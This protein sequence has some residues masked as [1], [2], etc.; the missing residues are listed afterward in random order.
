MSDSYKPR[1]GSRPLARWWWLSG[2]FAHA[3]IRDQLEWLLAN[4]FGGVELAWIY[5]GWIENP[6]S[7]PEWLGRE[8]Q[9]LVTFTKLQ[10][11]E[12]GLQCDFTFGSCWPF[13]GSQVTPQ[14]ASQTFDGLSSQRL[15]CSWERGEQLVVDHLSRN[16][17]EAYARPLFAA[18]RNALTGSISTLFCDSLELDT[19]RLSFTGLLTQFE[20]RF[21]YSLEPSL[22][23][24]NRSPHVRYDYRKLIGETIVREFYQSFT[25]LCHENGALSRLQCHG[26]PADLLAAYAAVDIPESEALLFPPAFSRIAAS[27]AAW[28]GKPIVSAEAFTCLYGFPGDG[29]A[30]RLWKREDAR[31]IRLLADALFANG[32]NQIVWHG[33]PFQPAG[34]SREFYA[35]VHVGHDSAFAAELPDLNR[36]FERTCELL[37]A[38]KPFAQLGIYL[39]NEDALMLNRLPEAERTPGANYAWEMRHAEMPAEIGGCSPTWISLPFLREARVE[40]N[41]IISRELAVEALYVDCQWLD[42]A[43]L[44]QFARL[45]NDGARLIWKRE[46]HEPGHRKHPDYQHL[47]QEIRTRAEASMSLRPLL[48]G[49]DLPPYCVRQIDNELLLFFAH[50]R[51]KEIR[52]PMP[53]RL[54]AITE[55]VERDVILHWAGTDT[56]YTLRFK[57]GESI[58]LRTN[59]PKAVSSSVSEWIR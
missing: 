52:Y 48:I 19:D 17:L 49:N 29:D 32:V 55:T 59:A 57:S 51:A 30:D 54:G 13:G 44:E 46:C 28:A 22:D 10:C 1:A 8:W 4:G 16:A 53:Y 47:Q 33:M 6:G 3:D 25:E 43:A 58:L 12:L 34:Q 21:G 9:S 39:P 45:A 5:P 38:G 20:E 14:H 27:A 2:P 18:L 56:P 36:Y 41:L 11:D 24:L 50:P 15:R 35:S 40:N 26:A 31:D 23:K 7:R 37:R 42:Y